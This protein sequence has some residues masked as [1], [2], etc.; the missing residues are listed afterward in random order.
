MLVGVEVGGSVGVGVDVAGA[1]V[2]SG[3]FVVSFGAFVGF[4]LSGALV[5]STRA[6]VVSAGAEV[7]SLGSVSLSEVS[8]KEGRSD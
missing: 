8:G 1:F 2:G 5:G 6:G 7:V 3:F 4:G